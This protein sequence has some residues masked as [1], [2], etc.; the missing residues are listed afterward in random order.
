MGAVLG[1]LS[2]TDVLLLTAVAV[3]FCYKIYQRKER[4]RQLEQ[5]RRLH[6]QLPPMKKRDLTL[7]ELRS[8]DG[9]GPDKRILLALNG[10]VFDVTRATHLY[11]KGLVTSYIREKSTMFNVFG[12]LFR[13]LLWNL[14]GPRCLERLGFATDWPKCRE[15]YLW[16]LVWL[17]HIRYGEYAGVVHAVYW[18]DT[19]SIYVSASYYSVVLPQKSIRLSVDYWNPARSQTFTPSLKMIPRRRN[20]WQ[21]KPNRLQ[22]HRRRPRRSRWRW[23]G[24]P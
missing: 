10:K 19:I 4:Q 12:R 14:C 2:T 7:E 3:F 15:R 23:T 11:G 20:P 1:T 5:H 24:L 22:D 17:G 21:T 6:P 16:W 18:W 8:F 9:T 13:R